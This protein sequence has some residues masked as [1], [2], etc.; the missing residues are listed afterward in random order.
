MKINKPLLCLFCITPL[1][2]VLFISISNLDKP[3]RIKLLTW[4]SPSVAIGIWMTFGAMSGALI[5]SATT[6]SVSNPRNTF[7]RSVRI[8]PYSHLDENA[9]AE[10]DM[11]NENIETSPP[12]FDPK[13]YMIQRDYR[14]PSPTVSVPYRV[15]NINDSSNIYPEFTKQEARY[16]SPKGSVLQEEE[17][18]RQDFIE[19]IEQPIYQEVDQPIDS[20]E[21]W[22]EP[23]N[24]DW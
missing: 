15:I 18:I 1:L 13:D 2:S 23:L 19:E 6:V 8:D 5:S 10:K 11:F 21:Q 24:Q 7:S 3:V 20:S 12:S 22:G 14:D 16:S 4:T 9:A 17:S